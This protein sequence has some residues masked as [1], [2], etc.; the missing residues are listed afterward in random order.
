MSLARKTTRLYLDPF[1]V[2]GATNS[3][4]QAIEGTTDEFQ[5]TYY[6]GARDALAVLLSADEIRTQVEF[7]ALLDAQRRQTTGAALFPKEEM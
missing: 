4:A 1:D 2:W 6:T 3:L 7:R 5:K